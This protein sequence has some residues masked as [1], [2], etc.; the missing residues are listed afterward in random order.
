M[1]IRAGNEVF[2]ANVFFISKTTSQPKFQRGVLIENYIV[3][4]WG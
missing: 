3:R 1:A 2:L 4:V